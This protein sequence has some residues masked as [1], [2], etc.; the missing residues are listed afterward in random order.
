MKTIGLKQAYNRLKESVAVI[1]D[2]DAL[3]YPSL[4][5]IEN[6]PENQFLYL[7]WELDGQEYSVKCIEQ[8]NQ[9]IKTTDDGALM[10][11]EDIEGDRVQLTLLQPADYSNQVFR[12]EVKLNCC[13]A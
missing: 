5:D 3:V 8:N 6:N 4:A 12:E 7:F 1:V 13:R 11:L 9:T 10:I 2:N